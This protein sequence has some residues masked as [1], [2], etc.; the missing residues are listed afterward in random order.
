MDSTICLVSGIYPP[1]SGGPSKFSQVFS[2]WVSDS[3]LI[4]SVITYSDTAKIDEKYDNVNIKFISRGIFL[5]LR[6]LLM[7]IKI[8]HSAINGKRILANGC[9]VEVFLASLVKR[10]NYVVKIPGDIV[11]ERATNTGY[12][13][14]NV[15]EF[16]NVELNLKYR[17]YR[18]IFSK[19]IVRATNVIVPSQHLYDLCISWGVQKE[20]ISIIYNSVD[21]DFFKP[22]QIKEAE[23]D[24]LTVTRLVPW[25][26]VSE[27]IQVCHSLK[28]KLLVVG[29]GPE[30]RN[31][32]EYAK[33]L[34]ANVTFLGN[35]EQAQ[36]P[37]IYNKSKFFVLNSTFEAT[38]YSLIEARA[39][40]LV[41]VANGKTGS[42]EVIKNS[43]D[44][45]LFGD[46]K[47]PLLRDGLEKAINSDHGKLSNRA[48]ETT[49]DLF[50]Q[51]N[52][53]HKILKVVM[54]HENR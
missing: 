48:I 14:V 21:L 39:C 24:V 10:F 37:E 25:K 12:T 2:K 8:L 51:R 38:S 17:I 41:A 11:W 31:L 15:D 19:S 54:N 27:L 46:A 47:T 30:F 7:S 33:S 50:D 32:S 34:G 5:P 16:Q 35:I 36:L 22:N 6:L 18:N 52:N 20:K 44:G 23:Y 43:Y 42:S 45:F 1:D 49:R 4:C 40:G 9:F 26:G 28:L 3:G 29:D 13:D 53:F